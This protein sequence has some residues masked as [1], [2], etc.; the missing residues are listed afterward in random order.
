MHND[1][2]EIIF[3][4]QQIQKRIKELAGQVSKNYKGK[5]LTLV[6]VLKGAT[7]FLADLMKNLK[8]PLSIDFMAVSSYKETESTGVVRLIMDLRESPENKNLLIIEDI[9]DT[10]LTMH[11]LCE[12]LKTRRPKSLKICSLLYKPARKI[13]DIK[14]DYLGFEVPDRFVVGYGMDYNEL[15]RNL[16]YIGILK[17]EVYRRK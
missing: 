7:I 10:G 9:I 4:E 5:Q 3:T 11:Y 17:P 2:A 6:S 13:K 8:I 15:Y 16:P 12:N 1:I 14:I